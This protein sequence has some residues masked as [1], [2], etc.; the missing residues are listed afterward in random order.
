MAA[1]I[2]TIA[3][4]LGALNASPFLPVPHLPN[5]VAEWAAIIPLVCHLASYKQDYQLLGHIAL[6]GRIEIDLLPRLGVLAGIA[7][8]L[9][10]G[11]EFIDEASSK[12]YSHRRVW[13]VKWGGTFPAANGAASAIIARYALENKLRATIKMPDKIPDA[14]GKAP[15]KSKQ[16]TQ[17]RRYQT[18]HVLRFYRKNSRYSWLY[19]LDTIL[20]SVAT[21]ALVLILML[22][23]SVTL[24]L[25]GCFGTS[26]ALL[27][28]SFSQIAC[29]G[30]SLVRPPGYL[31]SNEEDDQSCMLY[32]IHQ[33]ASIW[34]LFIGDRGVVD[35]LLNKTMVA[36]PEKS[37]RRG[38]STF[39]SLAH[40]LQLLAMTYVAAQ[41]GW[42]GLALVVFMVINAVWRWRHCDTLACKRWLESGGINIEAKSFEFTGRT[43]MLG[44]I[45]AFSGGTRMDW[46]DEIIT[47]HP[48]RDAWLSRLHRLEGVG[49]EKTD[50]EGEIAR[51]TAHDWEYIRRSSGLSF[52][53]ASVLKSEMRHTVEP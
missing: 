45:Q 2:P 12:G 39:L 6:T 25:F 20:A 49:Q 38:L 1:Y 19:R 32:S 16:T 52:A 33:N 10:K 18:L 46:M 14:P 53:A 29:R 34:Y 17:H 28:G 8:L 30:F 11:P 3:P 42:D 24:M 51:W 22:G 40:A 37:H 47:P 48:R 36:L 23:I 43:M 9:R 44:A 13:D 50:S 21:E 31:Q 7:R 41:K 15:T 5:I 35:T 27:C 4:N 26:V